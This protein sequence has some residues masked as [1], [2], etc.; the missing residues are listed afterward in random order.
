MIGFGQ[1]T[2]NQLMTPTDVVTQ[3]AAIGLISGAAV[4]VGGFDL[5][6]NDDYTKNGKF[7]FFPSKDSIN[8]NSAQFT[9]WKV[10]APKDS[11]SNNMKRLIYIK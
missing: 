1:K 5:L 3:N 6:I 9:K 11:I 7:S 2:S 8:W 10:I 4:L